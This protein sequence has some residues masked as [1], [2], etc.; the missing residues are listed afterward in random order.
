MHERRAATPE[1]LL[2]GLRREGVVHGDHVDARDTLLG[3]LGGVGDVTG[4]L[5]GAGRREGTWDANE[6]VC[7]GMLALL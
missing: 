4:H 6:D 2:P 1:L 3:E 7:K 5:R